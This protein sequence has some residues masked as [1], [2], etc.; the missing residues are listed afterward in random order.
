MKNIIV[1]LTLSALVL[2]TGCGTKYI[3]PDINCPAP[4]RPEMRMGGGDYESLHN[5]NDIIDYCLKL[6]SQRTC[7]NRSLKGGK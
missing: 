2:T 5:Y 6:E 3:I 7:I 4:A 1:L